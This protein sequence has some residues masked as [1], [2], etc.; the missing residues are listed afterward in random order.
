MRTARNR[1]PLVAGNWKMNFTARE[2]ESHAQKFKKLVA[3]VSGVEIVICAPFTALHSLHKTLSGTKIM[4][5]AQNIFY[6]EEGTFTGEVSARMIAPYCS[7]VILGHSERRS[8]F[9][10][11]NQ[12]V[13][14]KIKKA[15]QY[16]LKP[17]VCIG[18]SLAEKRAGKTKTVLKKMLSECLVGISKKDAKRIILTYEPIWAISEGEKDMAE[19]E[20]ASA[21]TVQEAQA[22]I[23]GQIS[24]KFGKAV[25]EQVSV[26]YGG[27]IKPSNAKKLMAQNDIDGGLIGGASLDP[28]IFSKVVKLMRD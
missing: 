28:A 4:L 26:L 7:H 1:I 19:S 12:D 27:S 21:E 15:L 24:K 2:A 6:E 20:A 25:S 3:A 22:F 10:E 13:N 5:G 23:R 16:G 14:K 8:L 17:I 9:H 18:E 11:T